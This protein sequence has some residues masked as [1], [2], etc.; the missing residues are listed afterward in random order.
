[1]VANPNAMRLAHTAWAG[2]AKGLGGVQSERDL[3]HTPQHITTVYLLGPSYRQPQIGGGP[4]VCWQPPG[5]HLV[6]MAG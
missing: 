3:R 6:E 1:M 5:L 4:F 2:G